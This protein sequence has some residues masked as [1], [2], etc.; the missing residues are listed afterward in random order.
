[1]GTMMALARAWR[2]RAAIAGLASAAAACGTAA[3]MRIEEDTKLDFKDVLIRPKRSTL[4]SR[5]QACTTHAIRTMRAVPKRA[6]HPLA[7][8]P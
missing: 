8:E 2:G 5:S 7:G 4:Q 1:M 3:C 6:G